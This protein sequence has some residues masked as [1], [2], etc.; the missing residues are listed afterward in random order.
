ML[1]SGCIPNHITYS[2]FLDR[3]TKEGYMEKAVQLHNAML[4]GFLAN[5][6]TYNMLIR[7]FCKLDRTQEASQILIEMTDNDIFPDCVSY[8][9]VMYEFCKSGDL[10][11]AIRLWDSMLNKGL[12][13]D[14]LAYKFLIHGCCVAGELT[15]AFE[16]RDDMTRRGLRPNRAIHYSIIHGTCSMSSFLST[17][18]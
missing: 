1:V 9:T 18:G 2:C 15:K 17:D 16:L 13:P 8:S 14:T 10:E 5:T 12:Q 6:V 3:L 11:V 7:G 4:K